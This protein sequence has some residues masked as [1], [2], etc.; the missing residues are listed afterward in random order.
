MPERQVYDFDSP[1]HGDE[2]EYGLDPIG[3][4]GDQGFLPE[5]RRALVAPTWSRRYTFWRRRG[6][7]DGLAFRQVFTSSRL[8]GL[9]TELGSIPARS[10]LKIPAASQ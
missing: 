2:D 1:D 3:E 7:A 6:D 10:A 4:H 8:M 9:L 5:V